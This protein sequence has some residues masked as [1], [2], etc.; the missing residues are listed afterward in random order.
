LRAPSYLAKCKTNDQRRPGG[1]RRYDACTRRH[2]RCAAPSSKGLPNG[3]TTDMPA[4]WKP[5]A[6][7]GSGVR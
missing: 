6:H 3:Y 1:S 5:T 2:A 7:A 4:K